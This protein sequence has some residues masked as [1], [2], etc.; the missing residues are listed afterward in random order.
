MRTPVLFIRLK[1]GQRMNRRKPFCVTP[2]KG[3]HRLSGFTTFP[4]G[5]FLLPFLLYHRKGHL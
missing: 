1:S 2:W 4:E 3:V 5:R